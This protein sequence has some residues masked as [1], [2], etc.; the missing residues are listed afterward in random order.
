[1]QPFGHRR[2]GAAQVVRV[3]FVHFRT[4]MDKDQANYRSSP[5][6]T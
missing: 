3:W 1:V 2:L 4:N 6:N 5:A